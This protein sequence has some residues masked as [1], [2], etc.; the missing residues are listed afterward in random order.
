MSE[1][2]EDVIVE[3]LNEADEIPE[4][5]DMN[6]SEPSAGEY[7]EVIPGTF[8]EMDED[9]E[10]AVRN[11]NKAKE[12]E[13]K[14]KE[15]KTTCYDQLKERMSQLGLEEYKCYQSR[16]KVRLR[17]RDAEIKVTTVKEDEPSPFRAAALVG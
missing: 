1:E 12:A 4:D 17:G 8:E 5:A 3:E 15:R 10:I 11:Y 14:A 2:D 6:P 9:L 7:Q 16:H 13:K